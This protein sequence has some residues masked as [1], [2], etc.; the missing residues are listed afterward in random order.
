MHTCGMREYSMMQTSN[1]GRL[2]AWFIPHKYSSDKSAMD[3]FI[4]NYLIFMCSK[5][6]NQERMSKDKN[7]EKSIFKLMSNDA[8][9]GNHHFLW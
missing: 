2:I 7:I 8:P 6:T 9:Y 1:V 3:G 5:H 4:I